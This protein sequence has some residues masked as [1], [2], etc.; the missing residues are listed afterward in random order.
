MPESV[1][2][3]APVRKAM[4]R[5][6]SRSATLPRV[7]DDSA[8]FDALTGPPRASLRRG[9]GAG[10][11]LAEWRD[12]PDVRDRPRRPA[13]RRLPRVDGHG[14]AG[15]HRAGRGALHRGDDDGDRARG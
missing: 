5:P 2:I 1:E 15:R 11:A 7:A 13:A 14:A 12:A 4:R 6:R 8:V 3:P 10:L 9:D